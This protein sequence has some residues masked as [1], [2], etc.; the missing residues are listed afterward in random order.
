MAGASLAA[1]ADEPPAKSDASQASA[2]TKPGAETGGTFKPP[3]GFRA[4]KRGS[5]V[6]YCRKEPVM[7]SRFPAEKCYDE[8]GLR[9]LK[10]A[11]LERT[12]MLER[13]RA[14]TTGSCST[15]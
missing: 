15:G 3:P 2:I 6:L 7:G 8:A 1:V 9:E 5:L 11:E 13:M 10:R 4:R 14:C 12:E